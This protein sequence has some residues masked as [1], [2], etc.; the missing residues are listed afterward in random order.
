MVSVVR[1][2]VAFNGGVDGKTTA[3]CPTLLFLASKRRS[4][5]IKFGSSAKGDAQLCECR[6]GYDLRE[7]MGRTE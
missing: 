2:I 6:L 4:T 5:K 1:F 3:P 7:R